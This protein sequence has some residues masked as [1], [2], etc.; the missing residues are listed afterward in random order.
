MVSPRIMTSCAVVA[1]QVKYAN[2]NLSKTRS[3]VLPKMTEQPANDGRKQ[4]GP[5]RP[6]LDELLAGARGAMDFFLPLRTAFRGFC[7]HFP[8]F[9]LGRVTYGPAH[10]LQVF[11]YFFRLLAELITCSRH[12]SS[13]LV[14]KHEIARC[15]AASEEWLC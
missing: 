5:Q 6:F 12:V 15:G 14:E 2:T 13:S 8:E 7:A 10:S 11:R 9:L 3:A 1:A 4:Y